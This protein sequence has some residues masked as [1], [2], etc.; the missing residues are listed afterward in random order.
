MITDDDTSQVHLCA[1][2]G[3]DTSAMIEHSDPFEAFDDL[4]ELV[5]ELMPGGYP[6]RPVGPEGSF[7]L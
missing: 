6:E 4:M 7:R 1:E 2:G 5:E 3:V